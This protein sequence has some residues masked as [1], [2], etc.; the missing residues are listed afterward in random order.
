LYLGVAPIHT[1]WNRDF[2]YTINFSRGQRI[3]ASVKFLDFCD[4]CHVPNFRL[5]PP[6]QP[7]YSPAR[8]PILTLLL[9]GLSSEISAAKSDINR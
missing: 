9:K 3:E 5:N 4:T 8:N 7:A 6:Q 2:S 1:H